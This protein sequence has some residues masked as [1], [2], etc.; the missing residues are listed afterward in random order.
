MFPYH[1]TPH[2]KK[3]EDNRNLKK[4]K[5]LLAKANFWYLISLPA[6]TVIA[7]VEMLLYKVVLFMAILLEN[8]DL[9]I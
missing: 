9:P 4:I 3:A 5:I 6:S 7:Q 1:S 8:I 2:P